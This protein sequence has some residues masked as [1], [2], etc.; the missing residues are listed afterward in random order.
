MEIVFLGTGT[1]Q[2]VPLIA[3]PNT[4]LDLKNPKNWRTRSS[5]HVVLDNLH[6][7]VDAGPDFRWQCLKNQIPAVDLFILTHGHTDHVVGMDDMRRYCELRDG[8][9]IP[10]YSTPEGLQRVREIYPYAIHGKP[11]S[12]GYVSFALHEMPPVLALD[13]GSQIQT[14]LLPHGRFET[15][16]LIFIEKSTGK[17]LVYFSDC[18]TV[19]SPALAL[20]QGADVAVLDGLRPGEH[21]THMSVEDAVAAAKIIRAQRTFITHTTYQIDYDTWTPRLAEDGVEIAFDGLRLVL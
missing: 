13:S 16:G 9:A 5:I 3:H 18:K 19:P 11:A 1:S 7:Q 6:V 21:P 20:A 12:G 2:G 15:L 14:T 17:K 4:G 8:A 10:V